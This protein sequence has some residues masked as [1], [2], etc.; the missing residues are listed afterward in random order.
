MLLSSALIDTKSLEHFLTPNF[1]KKQPKKFPRRANF[2][3]VSQYGSLEKPHIKHLIVRG[4]RQ[5]TSIAL[6]VE[7]H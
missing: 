3:R 4:H 6:P 5:P 2:L 7:V 1:Y